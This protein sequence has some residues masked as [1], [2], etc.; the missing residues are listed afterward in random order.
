MSD[1]RAETIAN[2]S[3]MNTSKQGSSASMQQIHNDEG[4]LARQNL[5]LHQLTAMTKKL[6]I[7]E[8]NDL[9]VIGL[10]SKPFTNIESLI[11]LKAS[12]KGF[13]PIDISDLQNIKYIKI[14]EKGLEADD[15][16][17]E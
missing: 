5:Q 13:D 6:V 11:V 16:N 1:V 8:P 9:S 2:C 4:N 3:F 15:D 14:D 10:M 17:D 12:L 7:K